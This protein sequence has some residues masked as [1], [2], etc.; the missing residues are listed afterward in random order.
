[1]TIELDH[2]IRQSLTDFIEDIRQQSWRGKE[3]EAISYYAFGHLLR[4]CRSRSILHDPRQ[5]GIEVHVPKPARRGKKAAI[6]KDLVIWPEPGMTCWNAAGETNNY[7]L[8]ILEWKA[9]HMSA[10]D[11]DWLCALSADDA[12]FTGYAVCLDLR[13]QDYRLSCTRVQN[14]NVQERWLMV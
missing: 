8:A 6:C 12:Q 10:Y 14:Q 5:I 11:V 4:Y 3:R 1:M 13:Q 7:P 9:N 2:I